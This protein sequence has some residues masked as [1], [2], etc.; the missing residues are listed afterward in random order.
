[1]TA[2]IL[3]PNGSGK[4][5][6]AENLAA[7]L[8]TGV[9]YY[10]ATMIPFGGEGRARVEK[11]RK[12]RESMGFVTIEKPYLVSGIAGAAGA[13]ALLEDVS[14]L[15]SNALF[16]S[17]LKADEYIVFNDI[18][19][20]CGM[21]RDVVLVSIDGINALP[22]YDDETREYIESLNR[23][24]AMLADYADKVVKMRE[25]EPIIVKGEAGA[26]ALG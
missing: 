2:L 3:G 16:D 9:M 17:N 10:I 21:C 1:M 13:V 14:N 4:S 8:S 22:E 18:T 5:A 24:N 25:G 26:D 12:Q 6:Y 23:L 20:L 7:R 11:H 15:L 19:T